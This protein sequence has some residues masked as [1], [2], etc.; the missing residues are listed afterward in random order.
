[1]VGAHYLYAAALVITVL[2]GWLDFRT[3]HIPNWLTLLPL[4]IAPFVH[5]ALGFATGGRS[6]AGQAFLFS[7]LG[8]LACGAVPLL[9]FQAGGIHGGDVKLLAALGAL[10]RTSVGIQCELYAFIVALIYAPARLAYEGKLLKVMGNTLMMAANPFLPKAR[11]RK[12][13]PEMMTEMRF[14]PAVAV[15]TAIGVFLSWRGP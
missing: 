12:I 8:A 4:C 5:L 10:C 6:A 7:V 1:M 14:G 9:L 2:A 15:G 13:S 11:R 3:G